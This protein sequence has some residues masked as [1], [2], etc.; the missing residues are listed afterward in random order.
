M[1]LCRHSK[2]LL[3]PN[4]S[5]ENDSAREDGLLFVLQHEERVANTMVMTSTSTHRLE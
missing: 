5:F 1:L 3:A 2:I 4:V